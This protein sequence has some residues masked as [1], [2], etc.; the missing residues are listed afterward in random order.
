M[1]ATRPNRIVKTR[2]AIEDRIA[3][4]RLSLPILACLIWLGGCAT[5]RPCPTLPALDSTKPV[6]ACRMDGCTLAPDF[7]FAACC[8]AHDVV[9]WQGGNAEDRLE[10]DRTFRQCIADGGRTG[11]AAV[12]Y[13][14]VRFGGV[15]W[16]P[17]PWRWGFGWSFPRSAQRAND[18]CDV[19]AEAGSVSCPDADAKP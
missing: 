19:E 2:P 9:Y 5:H 10:A 14:G 6:H 18:A 4:Y 1:A 17:T 13:R 8:D 11:L 16:L 15:G 3:Q 12:Y 7:N